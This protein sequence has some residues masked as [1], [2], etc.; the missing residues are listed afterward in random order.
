MAF[1]KT[2]KDLSIFLLP[3]RNIS[4]T[5]QPC[6]NEGVCVHPRGLEAQ[7]YVITSNAFIEFQNEITIDISNDAME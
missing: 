7:Q 2:I 6:F 1:W 5:M 4:K 3:C